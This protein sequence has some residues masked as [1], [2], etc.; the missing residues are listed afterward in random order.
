MLCTLFDEGQWQQVSML[1]QWVKNDSASV[2]GLAFRSKRM[3]IWLIIFFVVA[4][5]IPAF[6]CIAACLLSPPPSGI[7]KDLT[8]DCEQY[9]DMVEKRVGYWN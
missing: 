7:K 5:V 8:S 4:F 6:L 9:P 2:I 1:S 3:M